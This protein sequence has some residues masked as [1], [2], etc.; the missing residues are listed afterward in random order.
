MRQIEVINQE[1]IIDVTAETSNVEILVRDY[2]SELVERFALEAQEAAIEAEESADIATAQAS[3]ATAQATIATTQAGIATTQA[4]IATTQAGIATT[5]AN[6]ASASAASAL[7]SEQAADADRIA[8]QA[9]ASTA[10]T[11]A[12]IATTQAGIATTKAGEASDSA[13]AALASETDAETAASTATTQAG[14]ATTKA[15]EAAASA[16]EAQDIVDSITP[17]D[18]TEATSSVLTIT[19]GTDAVLGS[20]TTIQVKQAG[21]SQSGFLSSTDWTTFNSKQNTITNPVTGTGVSG[22][23]A[24]WDGSSSQTGDSGLFWDNANKRLGVGTNTPAYSISNVGIDGVASFFSQRDFG[25]QTFAQI[26]QRASFIAYTSSGTTGLAIGNAA[27]AVR[28]QGFDALPATSARPIYL[29]SLGGN[30]GIGTT[31]DAGF[32]LDVNGTARVQGGLSVTAGG[33]QITGALQVSTGGAQITGNAR[34]VSGQE[35]LRLGANSDAQTLTDNTNKRGRISVPQYGSTTGLPV[36]MISGNS[37]V[38]SNSIVIGG[39]QGGYALAADSIEFLIGA[40]YNATTSIQIAR[41]FSTGN[42][43][44]QNGG[45]FTDAGF[46][47]DVNGTARVRGASTFNNNMSLGYNLNGS[48]QFSITNTTSGAFASS[49]FVLN[50]NAT[51]GLSS[52]GKASTG[53][54]S[55]K[56]INPNDFYI[57]NDITA[58]DIAILNNFST[59]RIKLAAGGSSTAQ[60]TLFSTGNFAIGTTTDVASSILTVESTTKGF[61][62]PRMTT[63]EKNAIAS[64]AT[65]LVVYDN[66]LNKLSVFTGLVW[67]TVTSL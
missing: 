51:S 33:A 52:F 39:T 9:A 53:F 64:P 25:F 13:A 40:T 36:G 24:F 15:Q 59:G 1:T 46:R 42:L 10:T 61:L 3:I 41:F 11:Q 50:S 56:I 44:L 17:A 65:G 2:D 21:S 55:I 7:A 30:V 29:Q 18:L 49:Q 4:G 67:E 47:L 20:G 28:I 19:G 5:K 37:N 14:I 43:L 23:V 62:P 16:Q 27:G 35:G 57:Y 58:G 32:K 60:A 6:E 12:G 38:S 54:T 8:A 26:T 45:T 31:T 66:T 34:I 63:T 22:Q 48:A